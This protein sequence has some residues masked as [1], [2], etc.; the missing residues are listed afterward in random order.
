MAKKSPTPENPER[1][2]NGFG[3]F[4]SLLSVPGKRDKTELAA[5]GFG[6]N[7]VHDIRLLGTPGARVWGWW[8]NQLY[9]STLLGIDGAG[10]IRVPRK[11]LWRGANQFEVVGQESRF[12]EC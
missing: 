7:Q 12:S 9:S 1:T 6:G 8:E 5:I 10:L 3:G 11:G 4:N 2:D